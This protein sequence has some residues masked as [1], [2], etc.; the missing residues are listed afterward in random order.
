MLE[1]MAARVGTARVRKVA[2]AI[3]LL[4]VAEWGFNGGVNV[5]GAGGWI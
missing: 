1:N 3:N 4:P 2:A 5:E